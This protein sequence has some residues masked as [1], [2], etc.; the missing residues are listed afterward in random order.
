MLQQVALGIEPMSSSPQAFTELIRSEIP[1]WAL[2]VKASGAKV[3]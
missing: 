1:K 3:D 2:I